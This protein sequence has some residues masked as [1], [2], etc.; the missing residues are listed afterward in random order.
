MSAGAGA[1]P[2][3]YT[4]PP[5]VS[6]VDALATGLL[7]G[8]A[9]PLDPGDPL[10]L[11]RITILLPTRRACRALGLAF[12]RA[13]P[14]RA[15]LL[16]RIRPLGDIDEDEASIG[17]EADAAL[18]DAVAPLERRLL[19]A[20]LI[21]RLGETAG[22]AALTGAGR[23]DQAS[24]L[25]R[26]LAD[27]LDEIQI[28]RLD[29]QGLATL[30]PEEYAAHWQQVLRFLALITDNWPAILEER[31][32]IDP[33]ARRN[34]LLERLAAALDRGAAGLSR[35]RRRLDG[36][37]AGHARPAGR[38]RAAAAGRRRPPRPRCATPTT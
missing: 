30:A 13:S 20:R 16:P 38:H 12:L 11:S 27:L 22:G 4:V 36:E 34:A 17:D 14:G 6:F 23:V 37:P 19:L 5:H 3:L 31:G 8:R 29:A 28:A 7:S 25:A 1:A 32:L 26:A 10:A 9:V 21:Q 33:A 24:R 2:T 35:D 15:L 18:P